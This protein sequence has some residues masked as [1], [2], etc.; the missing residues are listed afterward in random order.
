MKGLEC[1]FSL[2]GRGTGFERFLIDH[3]PR[4]PGLRVC[5][6][7]LIVSQD[8]FF[9]VGG[10]S[11]VQG[12]ALFAFENIERE[13]QEEWRGGRGSNPRPPA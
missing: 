13:G 11:D 12:A 2:H 8:A 4:T 10:V 9:D 1:A 5:R 6:S 3:L 7:S